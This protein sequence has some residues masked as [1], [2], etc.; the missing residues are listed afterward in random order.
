[1]PSAPIVLDLDGVVLQTNLVKHSAMLSLF[2]EDQGDRDA[3]SDYILS[4]G[5]VR[6][7]IKISHIL[8]T[9]VE[10]PNATGALP[11]YLDA[12][13]A[14]LEHALRSAPLVPG[15]EDF[16]GSEHVFYLC[17]SAPER[18]IEYQLRS[19]GLW[20]RFRKIFGASTRKAVALSEIRREAAFRPI[21][22]GDSLPDLVAARE[23]RAS[24]VAVVFERDNFVHVPVLKLPDFTSIEHVRYCINAARRAAV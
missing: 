20:S 1:M 4:N 13:A 19:R 21:F 24:F 9:F 16:L 2:E 8:R 14:K 17:S 23:A 15:V 18:E 10:H 11:Q 7:D 12:Y 22:F 6:R 5:G 3:I